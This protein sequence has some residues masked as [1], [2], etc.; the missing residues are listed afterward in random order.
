MDFF[1]FH[2]PLGG[3]EGFRN[4][5]E[6]SSF[7]L[8][9][10]KL[11]LSHMYPFHTTYYDFLDAVHCVPWILMSIVQGR[12]VPCRAKIWWIRAVPNI[13]VP[14][15]YDPCRAKYFRAAPCRAQYQE[16]IV[17]PGTHRE[18]RNPLWIQEPIVNPGTH[19]EFRNPS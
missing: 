8:I 15:P 2:G 14:C 9:L 13:S 5:P 16:P 19:P 18:S 12:P 3:Q 11:C 4:D 1:T 10:H 6:P 7:L 17:N